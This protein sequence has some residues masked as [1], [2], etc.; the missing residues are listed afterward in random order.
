MMVGG[1]EIEDK[2]SGRKEQIIWKPKSHGKKVELP[3]II[4]FKKEKFY[5]ELQF[6]RFQSM[7]NWPLA[8]GL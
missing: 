1:E 6:W 4:D 7:T 3:E 8:L 5:F 2:Q